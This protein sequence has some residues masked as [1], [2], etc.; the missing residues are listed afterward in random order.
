MISLEGKTVIVTGGSAGIGLEIVQKFYDAGANAAIIDLAASESIAAEAIRRLGD[1][2]RVMFFPADVTCWEDM[3][4]V[5]T[6]VR[7]VFGRI[8]IV[9]ANA[10]IMESRRFFDFETDDSGNVKEDKVSGRVIDVNLK[11]T[12]N[13]TTPVLSYPGHLVS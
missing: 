4:L 7:Q 3:S 8:D 9:V 5:F 12:M 10:G 6:R 13:S 11:G 2:T 1:T